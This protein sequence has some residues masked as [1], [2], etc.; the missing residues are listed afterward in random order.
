MLRLS[1]LGPSLQACIELISLQTNNIDAGILQDSALRITLSFSREAGHPGEAG[2]LEEILPS[3]AYDLSDAL[4]SMSFL[5]KGRPANLSSISFY[6]DKSPYWPSFPSFNI[7]SEVRY[8]YEPE[9]RENPSAS[10]RTFTSWQTW[11][12]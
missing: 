10:N 11:L 8:M 2:H 7:D 12:E 9:F 5:G 4:G 1:G 3:I 6:L